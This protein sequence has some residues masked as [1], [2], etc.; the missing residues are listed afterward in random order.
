[1]PSR[2]IN[3]NPVQN[4]YSCLWN[5]YNEVESSYALI[6][7]IRQILNYYFI[8]MLGLDGSDIVKLF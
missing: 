8:E 1:M 7:V 5:T 4:S 6:N 2:M 3:Y